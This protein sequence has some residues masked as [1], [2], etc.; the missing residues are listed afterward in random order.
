MHLL[1]AQGFIPKEEFLVINGDNLFDLDFSAM[2]RVHKETDAAITIGLTRVV[3][4]EHYGV[5]ELDGRR[6]VRFVEKPRREEAPSNLIN[7][8]YYLFSPSIFTFL[9]VEKKFMLE[10]DL[11]PVV[12]RAGKLAGYSSDAQWFDTGTFERWERVE[13]EWRRKRKR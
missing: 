13:Q 3:D 4:V 2:R 9:P 6:I 10:K 12:A 11:F 5:V 8:G 7:G 1:K